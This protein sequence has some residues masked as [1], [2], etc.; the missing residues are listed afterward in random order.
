MIVCKR[1]GN[2]NPSSNEF[3]DS[4]GAFL[5]WE[6][7]K[8]G[9]PIDQ[10]AARP[11]PPPLGMVTRIKNAVLGDGSALPPPTPGRADGRGLPRPARGDAPSARNAARPHSPSALIAKPLDPPTAS[12]EPQ[13][14]APQTPTATAARPKPQIKQPPTRTIGPGD[15]V[16][17]TCGEV[18]G[19]ERH[20]CRRCA[21][22]LAEVVPAR[23]RWW[24]RRRTVGARPGS[25]QTAADGRQVA[26]GERPARASSRGRGS[27][28]K[29]KARQVK[30]ATFSGFTRVRRVLALLAILGIGTGMAVPSLRSTIT[31]KASELFNSAKRAVNP[32]YTTVNPDNTLTVASSSAAGHDASQI[33]D[34]G[35]NTFWVGAPDA[36]EATATVT[37]TP[38]TDLAKILI[39]PG[40]QS[41]PANFKIQ[42]RPKDLF[43][44]AQDATG[45]VITSIQITLDDNPKPQGFDFEADGVTSVTVA[46][47][48]CYPD[49]ALHVCAISE[50]EFFKLK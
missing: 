4:C 27:S 21:S 46:T 29:R 2:H 33:A 36:P 50:L 12:P 5:E 3:C 25:T 23:R 40:D 30:G 16:C 47:Q 34:G 31:N 22:S 39:T 13:Q 26:A 9:D 43:I 7:E 19:P 45:K 20:Y 14:P 49:P 10:A 28:A 11:L 48:T 1:C 35:S 8:I 44:T 32:D 24:Q 38:P 41:Q 17:G 15:L 6:G 18:N 42:P 37:F